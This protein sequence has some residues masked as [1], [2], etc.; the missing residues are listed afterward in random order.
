MFDELLDSF[1][2]FHDQTGAQGSYQDV[3]SSNFCP[4]TGNNCQYVGEGGNIYTDNPFYDIGA[5]V[6]SDTV[7][8]LEG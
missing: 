1:P 2:L 7:C 8:T 3:V 6:N 4:N 5:N